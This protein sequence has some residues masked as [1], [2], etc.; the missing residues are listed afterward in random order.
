VRGYYSSACGG[1]LLLALAYRLSDGSRLAL[2]ILALGAAV[3]LY[4]LLRYPPH[5]H[6]AW[7]R[8][9]RDRR[10]RSASPATGHRD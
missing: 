8:D 4:R 10:R 6:S 3:L 9:R 7:L 1:L 2:A 5:R